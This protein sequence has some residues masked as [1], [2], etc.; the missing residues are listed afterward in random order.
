[1]TPGTPCKPPE[2]HPELR[3]GSYTKHLK[4]LLLSKTSRLQRSSRHCHLR[5]N[6]SM[7]HSTL[8][9]KEGTRMMMIVITVRAIRHPKCHF[10]VLQTYSKFLVIS[11]ELGNVKNMVQLSDQD[12]HDATGQCPRQD[13]RDPNFQDSII[14]I[15][16]FGKCFKLVLKKIHGLGEHDDIPEQLIPS[17]FS[18][19]NAFL[20]ADSMLIIKR[21]YMKCY[22]Q[23]GKELLDHLEELMTQESLLGSAVSTRS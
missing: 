23:L 16:C 18:E 2:S 3:A 21:H 1:M 19:E 11:I 8:L 4:R 13:L 17:T 14:N 15:S 9:R 7:I 12:L 5:K 20:D 22:L 6:L 10:G